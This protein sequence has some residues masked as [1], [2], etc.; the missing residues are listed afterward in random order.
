MTRRSGRPSEPATTSRNVPVPPSVGQEL[1]HLGADY[2]MV[3]NEI[4][5]EWQLPKKLAFII[6]RQNKPLSR[7]VT[8]E[9]LLALT[10]SAGANASRLLYSTHLDQGDDEGTSEALGEALRVLARRF[11][12]DA[13]ELRDYLHARDEEV[14][15]LVGT[16]VVG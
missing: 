6:Q 11:E 1:L 4:A 5:R 16:I 8:P 12:R 10:V 15:E 13:R 9:A 7:A 2:E 14:R 3:G